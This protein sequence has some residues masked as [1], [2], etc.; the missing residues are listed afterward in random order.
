MSS[1]LLTFTN[2]TGQRRTVRIPN[3][4]SNVSVAA[5]QEIASIISTTELLVAANDTKLD[6]TAQLQ[7][8]TISTTA[9]PL[10]A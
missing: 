9:I 3:V 7:V 10:P 6:T 2:H 1:V 5:I 4:E 8:E